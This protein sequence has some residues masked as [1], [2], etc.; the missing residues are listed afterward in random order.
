MRGEHYGQRPLC[1]ASKGRTHGS[2]DQHVRKVNK[3][4]AK[5]EPSTHGASETSG[6]GSFWPEAVTGV[7]NNSRRTL[8]FAGEFREEDLQR[9]NIQSW[10]QNLGIQRQLP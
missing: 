9:V 6:L 10:P 7:A 8:T 3:P 1:A 4:L 2:S 5:P